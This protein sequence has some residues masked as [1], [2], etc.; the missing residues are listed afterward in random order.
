MITATLSLLLMSATAETPTLLR[1]LQCG[2]INKMAEPAKYA[3][4][5]AY[6]AGVALGVRAADGN[7]LHFGRLVPLKGTVVKTSETVI[8]ACAA[9]PDESVP[10]ILAVLSRDPKSEI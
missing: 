5:N 10:S 6:M 9:L 8:A 3:V 1:H 2:A 4:I 7:M